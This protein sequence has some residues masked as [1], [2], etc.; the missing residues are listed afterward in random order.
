MPYEERT[1]IAADLFAAFG[2][3]VRRRLQPFVAD[4]VVEH[5]W[6]LAV[7]ALRETRNLGRAIS[8]S[9]HQLEG[10]WGLST[11][12]LPLSELCRQEVFRWFLAHILAQLPRFR[13]IY[14]TALD[15]YRRVHRVRSRNHPVPAAVAQR[16]VAG[17]ALLVLDPRPSAP[18]APLRAEAR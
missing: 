10:E 2:P 8:Q 3:E 9:R 16:R 4:P 14:N 17:V 5:L 18:A 1:V 15:E 7:R 11:W 6:P 13:T 12:E